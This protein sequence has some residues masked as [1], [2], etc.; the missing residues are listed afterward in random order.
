LK[1]QGHHRFKVTH[2]VDQGAIEVNHAGLHL[3]AQQ[4]SHP[5][6]PGAWLE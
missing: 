1:H 2:G 4:L 6:I 3:H 5:S